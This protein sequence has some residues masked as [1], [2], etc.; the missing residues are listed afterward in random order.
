MSLGEREAGARWFPPFTLQG[1]S[2]SHLAPVLRLKANQFKSI[3]PKFVPLPIVF[4]PMTRTKDSRNT[5]S[6]FDLLQT[7]KKLKFSSRKMIPLSLINILIL[8]LI[9]IDIHD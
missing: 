9:S 1:I 8:L 5:I 3:S 6:S 7:Y 2:R 4:V